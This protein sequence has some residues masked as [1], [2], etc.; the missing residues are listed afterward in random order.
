MGRAARSAT[1]FSVIY[2]GLAACEGGISGVLQEAEQSTSANAQAP[3]EAKTGI[4]DIE[5][6]DVFSTT[7]LALWDG[8]P[9]LG[10]VWVAHPDVT[11]PE[12]AILIN[13][14]TGQRITGAL[15]RRERD[16]PG[17]ALQLSSDAA[18][19]LNILAGQ[20]T[21]V[22]VIAVRQE[23][24]EVEPA[25]PVISDEAV[26]DGVAVAAAPSIDEAPAGVTG[27]QANAELATEAGVI[28]VDDN[29]ATVAAAGVTTAAAT[30][31]K[32]NFLDRIFGQKEPR[33][34]I[35]DITPVEPTQTVSDAS[36]P[37]IETQPIDPVASSAAA[38]I[39][40]AEEADK[41][42]PRP[43]RT[44]TA[45]SS[46]KNPFV[47]VGLYTVKENAEATATNL[48]RAGVVPSIVQGAN[49]NG[50][51]WRVVAGPVTNTDDQAKLL[52]RV[53]QLGY[54]D[55]YLSPN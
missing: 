21:E 35:E 2:L 44:A 13:E 5:R 17:P 43:A 29:G 15:F 38:A 46:V 26:E 11:D 51:F 50:A 52:A 36:V 40:R 16:N 22:T 12:R 14:S 28:D 19:A 53:K 10:G 20:P 55:A 9:S 42:E 41:P 32:P 1:A 7:E 39:A 23:E 4:R 37:S 25:A 6:A 54:T 31:R 34:V 45:A 18:S 48:R 49:D 8:R 27:T 47:Q 24:F 3:A 33:P 30:T